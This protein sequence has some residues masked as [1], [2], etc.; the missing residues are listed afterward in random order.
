MDK[1]YKHLMIDIETLGTKPYCVVLS[2]AAVEFDI[3]TGKTGK[4][5]YERIDLK[6]SVNSKLQIDADTLQWW[7]NQSK[8]AQKELFINV[9]PLR[10]V[11]TKLTTFCKKKGYK[12]WGNSAR[13]D[14][15]II[16]SLYLIHKELVPWGKWSE[17]D[18]RTMSFL[19]PDIKKN[20]THEGVDHSALSDCYKQIGYTSKI[21]Q[22]LNSQL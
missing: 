11:L 21:Y 15:G 22:D 1:K 16:E 17:L 19:R 4:E 2:I 20:Y 8:E 10:E 5:F 6:T 3:E 12:V 18:V 14:L 7:F 9:K 13:F